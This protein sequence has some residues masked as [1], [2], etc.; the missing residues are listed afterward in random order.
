M[1]GG[2]RNHCPFCLYSMH[3]DMNV[4]GYRLSECEGQMKP[5]GIEIHKKKGTRIIHVCQKCG[6]KTFTRSAPDDDWDLICQLSK[7]PQE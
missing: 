4:P 3:V 5:V 1:E 7:I 2:C 6:L